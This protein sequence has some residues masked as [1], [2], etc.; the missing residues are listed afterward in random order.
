MTWSENEL[1]R[2]AYWKQ[3]IEPNTTVP[4]SH[5]PKATRKGK[6]RTKTWY[7]FLHLHQEDP[8]HLCTHDGN[9]NKGYCLPPN[10][11]IV[12]FSVLYYPGY[13]VRRVTPSWTHT[14]W[15]DDLHLSDAFVCLPTQ[16]RLFYLTKPYFQNKI[17]SYLYACLSKSAIPLPSFPKD[18]CNIWLCSTLTEAYF[19]RKILFPEPAHGW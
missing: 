16:G 18:D 13:L 12:F 8:F 4:L 6:L 15:C 19:N 3:G 5:S 1:S 10:T 2:S 7:D 17:T 14:I 9:K 11:Y